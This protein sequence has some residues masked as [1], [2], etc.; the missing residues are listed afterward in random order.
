MPELTVAEPAGLEVWRVG[1][2][3]DPWAWVGWEWA[4]DGRFGG[5]WDDSE[6]VF[7]TIYAGSALLACLL[8]LLADFRSDPLDALGG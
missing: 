7:R 5:R 1:Y 2:K 3:P 8:E 6:G 4:T